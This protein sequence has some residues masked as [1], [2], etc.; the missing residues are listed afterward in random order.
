M[1]TPVSIESLTCWADEPVDLVTE[2]PV[3]DD[4][5]SGGAEAQDK[6]PKFPIN[7]ELNSK[8]Y[9]YTGDILQLEVCD[10][11]DAKMNCLIHL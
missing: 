1:S 2:D 10:R 5:L 11:G 3:V 4:P 8:V 9:F 6:T 7:M